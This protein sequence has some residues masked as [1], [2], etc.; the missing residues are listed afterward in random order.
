MIKQIFDRCVEILY[1][2]G[3]PVVFF[4]NI[5][6]NNNK[7]G[8]WVGEDMDSAI[9]VSEFFTHF[10]FLKFLSLSKPLKNNNT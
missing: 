4:F 1:R 8:I 5:L 7:R 2:I 3:I 9:Y 10:D 6:K